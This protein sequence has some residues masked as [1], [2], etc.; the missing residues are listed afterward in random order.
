MSTRARVSLPAAIKANDVIEIKTSITHVMETG[1]R[2]DREGNLVPRNIINTVRALYRGDS[3]FVAELHPS[4][5]ANPYIA[6]HLKVVEPGE[7]KV[8]WTDDKERS[9]TEA[10]TIAFV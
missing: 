1:H 9:I 4:L 5:S 6:F 2:R 8:I 7:L 10:V 3:V